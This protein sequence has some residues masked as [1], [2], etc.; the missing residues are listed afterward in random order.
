MIT[1]DNSFIYVCIYT[2]EIHCIHCKGIKMN[3]N[4]ENNEK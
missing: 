1:N 4:V 3:K 2:V